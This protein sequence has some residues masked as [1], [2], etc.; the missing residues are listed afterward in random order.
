MPLFSIVCILVICVFVLCESVKKYYMYMESI[1]TYFK[2]MYLFIQ[3]YYLFI[4][5][6][7]KIVLSPL[8]W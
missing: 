5:F 3:I 7:H 1:F 8:F 4:P 6:G 2:V